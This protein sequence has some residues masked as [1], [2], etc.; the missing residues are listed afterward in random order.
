MIW[1]EE[2]KVEGQISG[3][4]W[5]GNLEKMYKEY[6]AEVEIRSSQL[7]ANAAPKDRKARSQI[8]DFI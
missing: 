2:E 1:I 3:V 6:W 5:S 8:Y 7:G 4:A